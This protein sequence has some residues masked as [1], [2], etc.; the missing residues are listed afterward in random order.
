MTKEKYKTEIFE[1]IPLASDIEK[2]YKEGWKLI[3][4][5]KIQYNCFI[6]YFK[7]VEKTKKIKDY[8]YYVRCKKCNQF[9]IPI[10]NYIRVDKCIC[11]DC[12]DMEVCDEDN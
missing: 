10:A 8:R 4:I 7:K 3:T 12:E 11:S 9:N 6:C 2:F 5:A 1:S